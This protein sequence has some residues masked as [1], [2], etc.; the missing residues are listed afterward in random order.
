MDF[1]LRDAYMSGYSTREFDQSRRSTTASSPAR[2]DDSRARAIGPGAFYLRPGR[3]V[4]RHLLPRTVRAIDLELQ[5]VFRDSKRYCFPAILGTPR[6]VPAANRVVAADAGLR[7]P[8]SDDA[9]SRVGPSL[10]GAVRTPPAL[11][12]GLRANGVFAPGEAERANVLSSTASF[13]TALRAELPAELKQLPLKVDT[14]RHVH[15]PGAHTPAAGQNFLYDPATGKIHSLDDRELF[16]HRHSFR[17]C[18]IYALDHTHE[19]QLAAALD[20]LTGDAAADEAT[21]M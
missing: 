12:D 5:E 10:A 4:L 15:R 8:E 19:A 17:I 7:W 6:R 2:A 21:N 1:V 11:E 18:R 13:E 9:E 16:A 3:I 14:A 20:R